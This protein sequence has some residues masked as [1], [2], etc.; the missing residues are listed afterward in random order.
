[1]RW[2]P[3]SK[4]SLLH[5]KLLSYSRPANS[6]LVAVLRKSRLAGRHPV[7]FGNWAIHHK[8]EAKE[9][10]TALSEWLAGGT[11]QG[12]REPSSSSWMCWWSTNITKYQTVC[13]DF[14]ELRMACVWLVRSLL[15]NIIALGL[16]KLFLQIM[17]CAFDFAGKSATVVAEEQS[18]SPLAAQ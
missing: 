11:A 2:Y 12:C 9:D 16:T 5:Q 15:M 3:R 17:I 13:Q 7:F 14:D 1:M 10:V 4:I 6:P 8:L 18:H